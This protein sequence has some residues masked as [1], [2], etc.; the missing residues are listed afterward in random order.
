MYF[1]RYEYCDSILSKND[2][3]QI[4]LFEECYCVSR[5]V[6]YVNDHVFFRIALFFTRNVC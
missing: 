6:S 1:T 4:E 5:S 3:V 2:A